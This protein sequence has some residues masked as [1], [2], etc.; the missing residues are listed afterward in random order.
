MPGWAW[1]LAAA[2]LVV[3]ACVGAVILAERRGLPHGAAGQDGMAAVRPAEKTDAPPASEA[4]PPPAPKPPA[5]PVP[6]VTLASLR[7][8]FERLKA[9]DGGVTREFVDRLRRFMTLGLRSM[10]E[11]M[12]AKGL[13]VDAYEQIGEKDTARAA[14]EEYLDC[15][16]RRC[17]A[18]KAAEETFRVANRLF[19]DQRDRLGALAYC[20]LLLT[21]Y[22]DSDLADAARYMTCQYYELEG[23][24]DQAVANYRKLSETSKGFGW[25]A[26]LGVQRVLYNS[27]KQEKAFAEVDGMIAK[28]P[29]NRAYLYYHKGMILQAAGATYYPAA[30]RAYKTVIEEY[31]KTAYAGY[32]KNMIAFMNRQLLGSPGNETM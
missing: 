26:S 8:E 5:A 16:E 25:Q 18:A 27:G 3:L 1:V 20:D 31:P 32:S 10:D 7:E 9:S 22:P 6:P 11:R 15:L 4:T 13:L 21:R 2:A 14:F 17:G 12:N 24:P 23:F 19:Y 29:E 30:V 28:H